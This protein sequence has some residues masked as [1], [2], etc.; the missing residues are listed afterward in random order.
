[1]GF[2]GVSG[3][4][5][6]SAERVVAGAGTGWHRVAAAQQPTWPNEQQADRVRQTL[7]G[8]PGLVSSE[9]I[10]EL[11]ELLR[12]VA[13]GERT[14]VQAGDCAEDPAE[15]NPAQLAT[16]LQLL[17]ALTEELAAVAGL[18]CTGI[19]RIAG[20]FAKPRSHAEETVNGHRLPA[21]RGLIVNDPAPNLAA[22][23]HDPRRLVA[24][25][26]AAAAAIGFLRGQPRPVWTSH[27]ALVLDYELPLLRRR[28]DGRLLLSSTHFPWIGDRTRQLT[29]A[30]VQLLRRI[31][32]PVA[33]KVGPAIGPAELLALC[34]LLD[35]EREPGRL[36]LIARLGAG[37]A[38]R[39]LPPLVEAVQAAGHPVIWLCDPMHGNTVRTPDG[40]K[41]RVFAQIEQEIGEFCRAVR[42]AG[43][44]AGGLHLET[45]PAAVAECVWSAEDLVGL[46]GRHYTTLCDPRLNAEQAVRAVRAWL[47]DGAVTR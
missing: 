37:V 2:N 41:S 43:G 7:A 13:H 23:T 21:F 45:T 11:R 10:D 30:H 38:E 46:D 18:P 16:K 5:L 8:L 4:V 14:I 47:P 15:C 29:G 12:E 1:M 31:D 40:R 32:N 6:L 19:G 25:Y 9:E 26:H 44:V 22:R 33:C 35:P 34:E 27:D 42:G 3:R 39:R 28:P 24:G 17:G 36:T 20:Q